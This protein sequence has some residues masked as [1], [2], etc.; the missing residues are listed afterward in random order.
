M[1]PVQFL[2]FT[3][4]GTENMTQ[5]RIRTAGRVSGYVLFVV[6]L[7]VLG[8]LGMLLRFT[9]A[10]DYLYHG[11]VKD[12]EREIPDGRVIVSPADGTVLYVRKIRDGIIPQ[13]L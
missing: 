1:P 8:S 13:V 10:T 6:G 5:G 11:L 7:L 3:V 12:P 2:R 4:G 9:Q